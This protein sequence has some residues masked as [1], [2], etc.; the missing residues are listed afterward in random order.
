MSFKK[1]TFPSEVQT[2]IKAAFWHA[3]N[4]IYKP[5]VVVT[6]AGYST[7]ACIKTQSYESFELN[8][9]HFNSVEFAE[10]STLTF[11]T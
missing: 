6:E 9:I 7:R 10:I 4:L 5:G 1:S 2:V 11:N 3:T 8:Y